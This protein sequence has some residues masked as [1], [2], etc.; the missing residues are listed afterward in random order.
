MPAPSCL[1]AQGLMMLRPTPASA[2]TRRLPVFL[3]DIVGQTLAVPRRNLGEVRPLLAHDGDMTLSPP[4]EAGHSPFF[5]PVVRQ[6]FERKRISPISALLWCGDFTSAVLL[7]YAERISELGGR[8]RI[9][10]HLGRR[11]ASCPAGFRLRRSRS[12][13]HLLAFRP[14]G[15]PAGHRLIIN[16]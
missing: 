3:D 5:T 14:S 1:S 12:Q 10:S 7:I 16:T 11:N 4:L 6:L 13:R 2:E 15:I 8:L 9:P